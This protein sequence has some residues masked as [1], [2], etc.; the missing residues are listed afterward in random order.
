MMSG[1]YQLLSLHSFTQTFSRKET[2]YSEQIRTICSYIENNYATITHEEQLA[3]VLHISTSHMHRIF[4]T[5]TGMTPIRYLTEHRIR[6]SKNLLKNSDLSIAQ[7][8][9]MIGFSNPNYFCTVFR[10][11][12]NG[13]SPSVYRKK[14]RQNL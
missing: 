9:D 8:S 7:I 4:V 11:Y 12:C 6:C 10:Q 1:L 14:Y 13:V 5:E 3:K 2:K